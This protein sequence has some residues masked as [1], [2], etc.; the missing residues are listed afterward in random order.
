VTVLRGRYKQESERKCISCGTEYHRDGPLP[1]HWDVH[2]IVIETRKL[3]C[4]CSSECRRK[5]GYA[6]RK[7]SA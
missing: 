4:S 5:M 2:Q 7:V 1:Y 6:E 3:V